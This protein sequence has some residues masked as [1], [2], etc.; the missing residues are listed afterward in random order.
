MEQENLRRKKRLHLLG[1][2]SAAEMVDRLITE[3]H[4]FKVLQEQTQATCDL[5][6]RQN[7][8]LHDRVAQSGNKPSNFY[9][10]ERD[11]NS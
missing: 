6:I 3:A 10:N 1:R 4:N 2:K 9:Y 11:N 8:M 5:L 7:E